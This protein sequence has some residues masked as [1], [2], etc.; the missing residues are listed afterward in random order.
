MKPLTIVP[1]P[2][3]PLLLL[4]GGIALAAVGVLL[5]ATRVSVVLGTLTLVVGGAVAALFAAQALDRRPRVIINDSGIYDR[6]M[7]VG[8]I[9]WNDVAGAYVRRMRGGVF[10][11]VELREP[12]RYTNRLSAA[13]R[14][15]AEAHRKLGL[16]E[17]SVNLSGTD[18]DAEALCDLI[19]REARLHQSG[20]G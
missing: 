4:A 3:R 16:T 8:R 2:R 17:L 18:A 19:I 6:T 12:E 11:C 13:L 20:E 1:S 14:Q 7:K 15:R 10:V 5:A 9:D